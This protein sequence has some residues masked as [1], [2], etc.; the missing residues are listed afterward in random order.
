MRAA[1]DQGID[2][3]Q[4]K[5]TNYRFLVQ[6]EAG[7]T[8]I[9]TERAATRAEAMY[10]VC[11]ANHGA[12][13]EPFSTQRARELRA[14]VAERRWVGTTYEHGS[15]FDPETW[16]AGDLIA[17]LR[18]SRLMVEAPLSEHGVMK[19]LHIA[20]GA[21]CD[22]QPLSL[23]VSAL[24]NTYGYRRVGEAFTNTVPTFTGKAMSDPSFDTAE[25]VLALV[26]GA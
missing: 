11:D 19:L 18:G 13:V 8:Q 15:I 7:H 17:N 24:T 5:L 20:P 22:L 23:H 25:D 4:A 16:R 6:R 9:V 1:D 2:M 21:K 26:E 14:T 3:Q 10:E 12:L